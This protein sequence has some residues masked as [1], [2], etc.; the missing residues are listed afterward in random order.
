MRPAILTPLF[1]SVTSL[2]GIG[3]KTLLAYD[4][5]IDRPDGARVVDLIFHTPTGIID[6][7][8][9][10]GIAK[11]AEG[12]TVTIDARIDRHKP[13][14][15]GSR[16]PYKVYAQDDTGEIALVFFRAKG[17]YLAKTLPIGERRFISG[18]VEW[19]NGQPQMAHPDLI[20]TPEDFERAA[21]VEPVYPLTEGLT[22]RMLAKSIANALDHLPD[23]PEWQDPAFRAQR[24]WPTFSEAIRT[25]HRPHDIE[26]KPESLALA[27]LAYD[28]LLANQLALALVRR[29]MRQAPKRPRVG[30]GELGA[31]LLAALPFRL[32]GAQEGAIAEIRTD[33]AAS[34]RMLRL[35]QGDV[36]SGKT[37]VAL[38]VAAT[39]IEADGQVALMAPTELLARQHFRSLEPHAIAS[40]LT[41][42]IL[43]GREKGREREGV[44]EGLAS[45]RI[46][47]VVGTHALFQTPVVFRDLTLAIIDEQHRFGV[48]QRLRL[49]AKGR[50]TDLLLMTATPIP[51]SLMMTYFG[52]VDSSRLTEKPAGRKPI[53]TRTVSVERIGEVVERIAAAIATGAK[54]YWVCPLV[55]ESLEVDLAAVTERFGDLTRLLGPVVGLVHGK[56]KP[57]EKDAAMRDFQSGVT[58]VLV[59]TTVIEVGVDVP[60]A[61]IMVIEHAE[62][63]GL[64]QLHQLR[65]RVGRGDKPSTCLLMYK[66]P[67]GEVSKA[68]LAIM[69]E[70]EDGFRI[71]EEDL[72]L[73]GGG[74]LLGTRQSGLPGFRLARLDIHADLMEVARDDARLVLARDPDLTSERGE[75]LR[76]LLYLFEREDGVRLLRAG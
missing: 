69:R 43:T 62:R 20:L 27:R 2:G 45:G 65:G 67:L 35:L 64:A 38:M 9:M 13:P 57:D 70:S 42:A 26:G 15:A 34:D 74:E 29:D 3:P 25:L 5:L 40:G 39:A 50:D 73:R 22:G 49:A 71:A 23:L 4:R 44:L 54:V 10:P 75:A 61:T 56:M 48:Q 32:T 6:R 8:S 24:G 60:D 59:A 55:D 18:K 33:M 66:G 16:Q 12:A 1:A 7:R 28:E 31:R 51:R 63:F 37:V 21:P 53:E 17:D 11:A 72:K 46:D 68:R 36:G 58:R 30:T 76:V 47:L 14:Q 41:I 52:D 19:F